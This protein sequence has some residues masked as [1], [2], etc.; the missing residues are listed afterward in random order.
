MIMRIA[1]A[2][3]WIVALFYG[4]GAVVHVLNI[5]SLTGFDWLSAPLKWQ[6][7]DVVYLVL[8]IIVVIGFFIRWKL[9]YFA[10][11]VAASSQIVL[12]TAFREWIVD[13]PEKFAVSPD[14]VSYLTTLVIFHFVTLILVTIALWVIYDKTRQQGQGG[15][16]GFQ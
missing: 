16:R 9:S 14:Q 13:V 6:V 12:Y 10:F 15:V 3:M 2:V 7:L 5:L 8:D 4:Y 1:K 11:Y